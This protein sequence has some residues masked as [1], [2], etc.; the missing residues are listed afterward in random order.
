MSVFFVPNPKFEEE[1]LRSS[2]VKAVLEELAKAGAAIYRDGVPV[3]EGDLRDSVFGTVALTSE[4]Y[5]GRIGATDWKAA[6][7]EL[8]GSLHNP[9]GSLRRAIE[10]IGLEIRGVGIGDETR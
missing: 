8:G 4:G 1:L 7:I 6:L 5:V 10:S 9:D 3:A 2:A